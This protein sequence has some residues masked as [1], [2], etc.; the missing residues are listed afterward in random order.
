[1]IEA[2]TALGGRRPWGK[3]QER[4]IPVGRQLGIKARGKLSGEEIDHRGA[5]PMLERKDKAI[6]HR[7]ARIFLILKEL[8]DLADPR[9]AER[10]GRAKAMR[11]R[12]TAKGATLALLQLVAE[13][14]ALAKRAAVGWETVTAG[15]TARH[16]KE[17][18]CPFVKIGKLHCRYPK[19]PAVGRAFP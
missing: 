18:E 14:A 8:D 3:G 9:A 19:S 7:L 17:R 16:V 12:L 13:S 5:S 6:G 2:I 10:L 4:L 1:M 11:K 15:R